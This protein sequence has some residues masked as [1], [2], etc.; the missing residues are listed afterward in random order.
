MEAEHVLLA[1]VLAVTFLGSIP[2]IGLTI[3]YAI[4]PAV[5]SI[6]GAIAASRSSRPAAGLQNRI[7]HLENQLSEIQAS[8]SHL[9][10]TRAFDR[11]LSGRAPPL[12]ER[13]E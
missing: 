2:L 4:K 3:R 11:E 10:E 13:R 12:L 5:E 8:L 7:D 6:A 9:A 1:A